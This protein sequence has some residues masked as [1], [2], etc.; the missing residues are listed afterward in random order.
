MRLA[1]Y[2]WERKILWMGMLV[3]VLATFGSVSTVQ[4]EQTPV[5]SREF[6]NT[7]DTVTIGKG[8]SKKLKVKISPKKASKKVKWSTSNKKVVS[9]NSKGKIKGKKKGSATITATAKDGSGCSAKIKVYVGNEIKAIKIT[10]KPTS[11]VVKKK[12]TL[13]AGITP[14]DAAYK[15]LSWK[16]SNSKV[17]TVTSKGVVK[18]V[19]N[20]TVKITATAKDGSSKKTT[21]KIKVIT[22]AK[23]VKIK[24]ASSRTFLQKGSS[25]SLD[26]TVSP[27]NTSNK[28]LQWTSSNPGVATVSSSGK[29]KAVGAGTVTITATTTDGTNKL[30]D[31]V[32]HVLELRASDNHFI[33]HRG[34]SEEAPEN[35]LTAFQKAIDAGFYGVEFDVRK[36]QDGVFVINHNN[37]LQ[38][39]Y[40][41][42]LKI[43]EST[44][45]QIRD[46]VMVN[47]NNV[48]TYPN[49]KIPTLQQAMNLLSQSSSI[50]LNIELKP[51]LTEPELEE[52]MEII[53]SYNMNDRINIISFSS[54][55]LLYIQQMLKTEED[56]NTGDSNTGDGNVEDGDNENLTSKD[57][58]TE[59]TFSKVSLT[60]LTEEP[61]MALGGYE[62]ALEWCIGKR[63][64]ISIHYKVLTQD[65]VN[66]IHAAGL[67]VGVYTVNNF[68]TAFNYLRNVGVDS[69]TTNKVLFTR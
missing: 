19:A 69:L 48:N 53:S 5:K 66:R 64:N 15:K 3:I 7:G 29:V 47:G 20:G 26:A 55:N 17:A 45:A 49:E 59:K 30:D 54:Q 11:L 60:Y 44:Y 39:M 57:T 61:I 41:C 12:C 32:L 68:Y 38:S 4:A 28:K 50:H 43:S 21:V 25:I 18:G 63:I 23:S 35:S 8:K 2:R 27:G 65:M 10:N 52:F 9:V 1:E 58:D 33:A 42:D 16:S 51:K 40:A 13:K 37:S 31:Y 67:E 36:T 22:L 56:D 14:S 62:D 6:K 34:Y 46:L 24:D